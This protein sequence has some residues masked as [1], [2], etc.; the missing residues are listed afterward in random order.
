L[1]RFSIHT[2]DRI[3]DFDQESETMRENK[4]FVILYPGYQGCG[5]IMITYKFPRGTQ[6][7]EHPNPGM[8]YYLNGFP[9]VAFLPNNE[10]GK[11]VLKLLKTAFDRRLIFTVRDF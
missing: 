3:T 7:P 2:L 10:K 1:L 6:G 4:F 11:K 5:K 8:P 9:R